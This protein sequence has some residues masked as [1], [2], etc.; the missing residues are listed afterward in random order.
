MSRF[1]KLKAPSVSRGLSNG[2]AGGNNLAT[3]VI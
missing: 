1:D 3:F 2:R